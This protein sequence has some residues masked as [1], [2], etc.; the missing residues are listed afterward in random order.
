MT[1]DP[2]GVAAEIDT[3]VP[4][5]ARVYDFF[6]GG[7]HNYPADRQ[8][9]AAIERTMPRIQDVARLNR[10]FLRRAVLFMVDNGIR[11][12]LDLGS[13]I[14]T[15]GNVHE[16][17]QGADPECRVVYVDKE[18]VAVAH[19]RILLRDN[20]RAAAIQADI[21]EP[22]DILSRPETLRL[23]DFDQPVGLL[24]LLVWHF[25]PDADDPPGLIARYRDALAPGSLFALT[26]VTYEGGSDGLWQAVDNVNRRGRDEMVPRSREQV[27][28]LFAGFELVDPGV[29]VCAAWRPQGPGDYSDEPAS[30]ALVLAGVGRKPGAGSE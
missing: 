24:S 13:G 2:G 20:E 14:P 28:D 3:S 7:G 9:A 25:V 8:L 12:F 6:L 30:N 19:S 11:Q 26:H 22:D 23:L 27:I 16:I 29:V 10:S 1:D 4:N 15:V 21:R 5:V 18:P 17:A